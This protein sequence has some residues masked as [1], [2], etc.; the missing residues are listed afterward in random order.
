MKHGLHLSLLWYSRI[1][2]L[3]VNAH[4]KYS[5][6]CWI[7]RFPEP[8]LQ[9]CLIYQTLLQKQSKKVVSICV[10]SSTAWYQTVY[11]V[12]TPACDLL[13]YGV[14][15]PWGTRYPG[16]LVPPT[17][18]PLSCQ[19]TIPGWLAPPTACPLSCPDTNSAH[20]D[21]GLGILARLYC[22]CSR[23][24]GI[25]KSRGTCRIWDAKLSR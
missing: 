19:D 23:F 7:N 12:N 9:L 25:S 21:G 11:V 24:T 6:Y 5:H 8:V 22:L 16:W 17:A 15:T 13:E 14:I 4:Y 20:D 3:I 18:C 10:K 1:A 2:G